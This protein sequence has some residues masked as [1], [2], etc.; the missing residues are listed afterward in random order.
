MQFSRR[1]LIVIAIFAFAL[2]GIGVFAFIGLQQ[3]EPTPA[4][5]IQAEPRRQTIGFSLQ[6]REIEAYT[7]GA[8]EKHLVFIGGIHGG[9]EWNT[10][11]LAYMAIDYFEE[12]PQVFPGNLTVTVI[13]SANPDGLYK[14][15]GKERRFKIADGAS[16]EETAPGRFNANNVDLNRN[17]DC[18]WQPEGVWRGNVVSAGISPFSEPE[19]RAIRDFVLEHKPTAV[20]FWHS[21]AN[22]VYASSCGDTI[23]P[24]TL[25]IMQAYAEAANYQAVESFDAYEVTGAAE[26][27]VASLGIPALTVELQTHQTIEWERNLEGIKALL[28]Y[29][30][31]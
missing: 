14:V 9:Y 19:A 22:A 7:Y 28:E 21:Q 10:V 12:N 3:K 5:P 25:D 26:D 24:E 1:M 4:S 11:L 2:L 8:G 20:L 18:E 15:I 6:G 30:E 13:P 29:Y 23:L 16:L 17:F 31:F 27:W